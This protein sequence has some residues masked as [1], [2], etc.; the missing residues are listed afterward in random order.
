MLPQTLQT[1]LNIHQNQYTAGN[2]IIESFRSVSRQVILVAQ[3]QSGKTGTAKYVAH[4]LRTGKNDQIFFICGMNDNDL[5]KQAIREF[6]DLIEPDQIL[7]S[8]QLQTWTHSKRTCTPSLV[9]IDE[10]HYAGCKNSQVDQFLNH[11]CLNMEDPEQMPYILS[12]SA[13]PMAEVANRQGKAI[14]QLHPSDGYYS[15]K[16]IFTNDM[17]FQSFNLSTT[18]GLQ[19]FVDLVSEEFS[20]QSETGYWKYCIVRLPNQFYFRDIEDALA[21][22]DLNI[23][24]LNH[25]SEFS[26]V[27]DFNKYLSVAPKTMTIIWIYNSLRAGKQLDT[28]HI[29]FV[30]DTSHSSPDTIAQALLGRIL[31]Y[32]KESH[33]VKCYTDLE[34]ARAMLKWVNHN[35]DQ[36]FIPQGSKNVIGGHTDRVVK[37]QL[38]PPIL[39]EL[40]KIYTEYY[41]KLVE[42]HKHRYPYR[43][44]MLTDIIDLADPFNHTDVEKILTNYK[45]GKHGGLMILTE[46][47]AEQSMTDHWNHNYIAFQKHIPV[48][49]F[50][51]DK[52]EDEAEGNFYYVFVNLNRFSTD[53]GKSLIVYKEYLNDVA[54]ANYVTAGSVSRFK[55]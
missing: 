37:W 3:M 1:T 34:A 30:H 46:Y 54:L 6:K 47:N 32:H 8:K 13:T 31:G 49:G 27:S 24:F 51:A 2:Q 50:D 7:F 33:K 15:I 19:D 14:V 36:C 25:H 53:Y 4:S 23:D 38:H 39:V 42:T 28:T 48:R 20:D 52:D 55:S 22:L 17:I 35:F 16:D 43:D 9:I 40:P 41:R 10:S 44:E 21:E 26:S 12:V 5:R 45:P 18:D 29:G 11:C